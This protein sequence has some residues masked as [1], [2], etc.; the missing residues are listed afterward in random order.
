MTN[1]WKTFEEGYPDENETVWLHSRYGGIKIALGCR[2]FV[3][4]VKDNA[5]WMWALSNGA[6]NAEGDKIVAECEINDNYA[7]THWCRLPLLP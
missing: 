7:F 1:E 2:V 6:I 5:S 4:V 3:G